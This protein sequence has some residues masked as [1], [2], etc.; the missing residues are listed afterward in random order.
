MQRLAPRAADVTLLKLVGLLRAM[1]P[2][3]TARHRHRE[4]N[5]SV[6]MADDLKF[7]GGKKSTLV[8][9]GIIGCT[10]RS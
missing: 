8:S 6:S 7:G 9:V 1:L 4:H 10:V 2:L 3:W 5:S